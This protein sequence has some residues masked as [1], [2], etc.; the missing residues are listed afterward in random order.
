MGNVVE[1]IAI[2]NP[3]EDDLFILDCNVLMYVFYTYGGYRN[4]LM[5]PYKAFFNKIAVKN[6]SILITSVLLSEFI[7]SYIRNEYKRYLRENNY[8]PDQFDFKKD[9]KPTNEYADTIKEISDII[10]NQLL[11]L[12]S[13]ILCKD[14]ITKKDIP[15]MFLNENTFDFND[16]YYGELARHRKCYIVTNDI[17]FK[18]IDN[19]KIVTANNQMLHNKGH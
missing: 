1:D 3:L 16:R 5:K 12:P 17:D 11:A 14:D 8:K 2:F 7:N 10:I 18:N 15:G 13:V 4:K 19:I 9:Y 6:E